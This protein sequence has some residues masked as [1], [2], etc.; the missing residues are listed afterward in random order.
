MGIRFIKIS[1]VYFTIGVLLGLYMSIVHNHLL[2]GVHAHINLLGW[3]SLAIVG[4]IY[5]HFPH[6]ATTKLAKIHFWLHNISL[7]IMMVGLSF[8]LNGFAALT[9]LVA[10]GG[11]V[12]VIAIILFSLNVLSKIRNT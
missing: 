8:V 3:V 11:T 10:L 4:L 1:V 6:L 12:L 9:P 2:V 7:P 5:V